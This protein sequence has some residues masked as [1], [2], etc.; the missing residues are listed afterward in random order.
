MECHVFPIDCSLLKTYHAAL[1]LL[2]GVTDLSSLVLDMGAALEKT[3]MGDA[4]VGPWDIANLVSD[5]LMDKMGAE[6]SSCSTKVSLGAGDRETQ[7]SD[8]EAFHL[9]VEA[10]RRMENVLVSDFSRYRFLK[11]FMNNEEADWSVVNTIVA[12]Y[13]GYTPEDADGQGHGDNLGEPVREPWR[14]MFPGLLPPDVRT[15]EGVVEALEADFP[16]DPDMLEGLEVIIETIYGSDAKQVTRQDEYW[17]PMLDTRV[18]RSA[19]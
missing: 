14:R 2:Q 6:T 1:N 11:D 10:V 15:A 12:L 19:R 8:P 9:T 17:R 4:F 13:Q 16:K 3:D 7:G 5:V 18:A